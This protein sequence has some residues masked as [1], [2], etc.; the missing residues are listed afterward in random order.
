MRHLRAWYLDCGRLGSIVN[1]IPG[2]IHRHWVQLEGL[3]EGSE[4]NLLHYLHIVVL[5]SMKKAPRFEI[6]NIRFF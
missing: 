5:T 4:V 6:I 3:L 1:A 2:L